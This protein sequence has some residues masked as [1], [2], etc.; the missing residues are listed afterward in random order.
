VKWLACF[1][2]CA[3][4]IDTVVARG[5]LYRYSCVSHVER[6][7]TSSSACVNEA[8]LRHES[9]DLLRSHLWL[10]LLCCSLHGCCSASMSSVLGA[11]QFASEDLFHPCVDCGTLTA[12]F[13]DYCFAADRLPTQRWAHEQPTPLCSK[14]DDEWD[15]CRY[16]RTERVSESGRIHAHNP[17]LLASY[18]RIM[19]NFETWNSGGAAASTEGHPDTQAHW[20]DPRSRCP[21]KV[22]TCFGCLRE[23]TP[24]GPWKCPCRLAHY[25][26]TTCQRKHWAVHKPCCAAYAFLQRRTSEYASRLYIAASRHT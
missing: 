13:C 26:G 20:Q 22:R 7:R 4:C 25:C 14:C 16:C 24:T 18:C 1:F 6:V 10:K 2:L 11:T 8:F 3:S 17:L 12:R 9:L 19:R 23:F 15:M 5:R 21:R